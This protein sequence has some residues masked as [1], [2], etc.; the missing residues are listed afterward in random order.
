MILEHKMY[1]PPRVRKIYLL[2][3]D[4]VCGN[5]SGLYMETLLLALMGSAHNLPN[6][7]TG[8]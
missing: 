6:K 5:V 2:V 8:L 4:S 7:F 1:G 3:G